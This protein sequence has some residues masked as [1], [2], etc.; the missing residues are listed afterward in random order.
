M[1]TELIIFRVIT[2]I[3]L[4]VSVLFGCMDLMM[5]FIA[6]RNPSQLFSVFL[7]A[8]FVVYVFASLRFLTRHIDT[9]QPAKHS[10]R[11]WIRV[12][13]F[14]SVLM[15]LMS[16]ASSALL[17]AT[18]D[19][20]IREAINT[21]LEA[22]PDTP[23][24]LNPEAFVGVVKTAIWFMLAISGLLAIHLVLNFR[25]LKRYRYLFEDKQPS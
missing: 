16:F 19:E 20:K 1:K 3:L 2:F 25:L 10:L 22:Q 5:F 4:P 24:T 18:G 13:G 8:A 6:L 9:N 21:M 11:D 14:A 17:I 7:I 23:A 15:A 12:N